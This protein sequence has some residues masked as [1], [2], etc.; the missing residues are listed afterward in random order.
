MAYLRGRGAPLKVSAR[1]CMRAARHRDAYVVLFAEAANVSGRT[2]GVECV[3]L[4][5]GVGHE[6]ERKRNRC[7]KHVFNCFSRSRLGASAPDSLPVFR[8]V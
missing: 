2:A 1:A 8:P 7:G 5:K 6:W 4:E 3:L